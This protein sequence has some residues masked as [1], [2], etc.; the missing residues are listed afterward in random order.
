MFALAQSSDQKADIMRRLGDLSWLRMN[1]NR[2]LVA[3]Y[4][5]PEK[6]SGGI[7]MPQSRTAESRYQGKV[8]LVIAKGPTAFVDQDD[9]CFHG[10]NPDIGD[11]VFYRAADGHELMLH[12]LTSRDGVNCRIFAD[13]L[14][15]GSIDDPERLW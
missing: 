14:I 11:W 9:V 1:G 15:H 4:I 2:V 6:S 3:T 12:T 10:F 5:E 8:G 7:I 13:V